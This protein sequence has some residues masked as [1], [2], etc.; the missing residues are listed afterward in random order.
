MRLLKRKL[1]TADYLLIIVNL[2]PVYGVWFEGWNAAQIFLVYCLET[3]II[4]LF[5]VIKM[6]CV[7]LLVKPRDEWQSGKVTV[8]ASG[9][10]FILFFIVHYGIFIF[11]QTQIFFAVSGLVKGGSVLNTYREIPN[12]LGHEGQLLLFIFITYYTLQNLFGFFLSGD[13]KTIPMMKLMF[14]PYGRIFVQQFVVIIGSMFLVFGV[15][16]IFILILALVKI[17]FETYVN[18]DRLLLLAEKKEKRKNEQLNK[19]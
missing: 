1:T 2:I 6:A 15:S 5:T 4:G 12:A 10:F 8:M 18:F 17:Y 16:K 9:I 13:Y 7:T 14:Q 19:F 11:V 3:V